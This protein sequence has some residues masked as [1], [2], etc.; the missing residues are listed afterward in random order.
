M[1]IAQ[2]RC[3]GRTRQDGDTNP[4]VWHF[5]QKTCPAAR[6]LVELWD[7]SA[8]AL[9]YE[10]RGNGNVNLVG[11]YARFGNRAPFAR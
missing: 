1:P 2:P 3:R 11:L 4:T 7:L 6:E 5:S 8:P 9:F 10:R